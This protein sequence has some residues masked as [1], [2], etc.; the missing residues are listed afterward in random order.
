M[1]YLGMNFDANTV[2]P[3]AAFEPVPT[4]WYR[5][6]IIKSEMKETKNGEGH[7]L[8][9]EMEILEGQYAGCKLW[10]R[11]NLFNPN[12]Q[13]VD[14][15]QRTLSAICHAIG[16][17][18]VTDSEALHGHPLLA[19]AVFVPAKGDYDAKN[20]IKGYKADAFFTA[21]TPPT[22][23]PAPAPARQPMPAPT[24]PAPVAAP[25][26]KRGPGR[27]PKEKPWQKG[28]PPAPFVASPAE[29]I[30]F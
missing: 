18:T 4:G 5:V 22:P 3:N 21:S 23:K 11:L 13:A 14:I 27:P 12:Q 9:L 2:E 30:P 29:D 7:Y 24:E 10:D 19:R 28:P 1:A 15:A 20:D 6:S 8:Q 25:E 17:L 16:V 26:L